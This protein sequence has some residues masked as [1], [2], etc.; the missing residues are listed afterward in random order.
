MAFF[1]P[2]HLLLEMGS[3]FSHLQGLTP[4]LSPSPC[5]CFPIITPNSLPETPAFCPG[6]ITV[7][8][9]PQPEDLEAPKTHHFKVKT[10]K[11]VKP[12]GICRQVIT[13]EGCTCKGEQLL[14][15]GGW[16][17]RPHGNEMAWGQVRLGLGFMYVL[18][19]LT[20]C[21]VLIWEGMLSTAGGK[22]VCV[23]VC[24]WHMAGEG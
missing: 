9:F 10:F 2:G 19:V 23:C 14:E 24:G 11:K 6:L 20:W 18:D 17:A 21:R 16:G 1:F 3:G 13:R 7:P 12:C 22:N 5:L 8:L 15:P 4:P